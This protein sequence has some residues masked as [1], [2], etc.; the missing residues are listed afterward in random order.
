MTDSVTPPDAPLVDPESGET[1]PLSPVR[2]RH[3][4]ILDCCP[5]YCAICHEQLEEEPD[6]AA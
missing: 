6:N 3:P 4:L 5:A 2:C 1:R